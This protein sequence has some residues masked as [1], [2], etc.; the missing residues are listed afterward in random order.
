MKRKI[1]T[2]I[3]TGMLAISSVA[4][5]A[6]ATQTTN[7]TTTTSNVS[8]TNSNSATTTNN[9]SATNQT[10]TTTSTTKIDALDSANLFS[11]RDKEIGYDETQSK[12]ITLNNQSVTISE[13]GTYILSGT[14]TNGQV[15]VD[16]PKEAKITIVL[17]GV[18]I[19]NNTSAAIYVKQADKV[20]IT[21]AQGSTN[22]LSN[23][24]EFVAI[25]ENNIDGV[26]YSKEDLTINGQGKL[27]VNANYGNAIVSKDDLTITSGT[28]ELTAANHGLD[29]KDNVK[30]S[31]GTITINAGKDAI[32][33]ENTDDTSLGYIYIGGGKLNLTAASDA[34]DASSTIQIDAGQ[35]DIKAEDDG[36]HGEKRVIINAGTININQSAEGIEGEKIDI[37]GGDINVV[38]QDDGLNATS[39]STTTTTTQNQQ[40]ANSIEQVPAMPTDGQRPVPPEF[41][42]GQA[43]TIPADGQRPTPPEFSNGQMMKGGMGG[44]T[45]ANQVDAYISISGGNLIIKAEGDG[46]DSNG[47]LIVTGGTTYVYGPTNSG[48]GSLDY[49]G[50]AKITGGV[51]VTAGSSGMAQNFGTDST[52]GT[53]LINLNS[54]QSANTQVTVKNS[55]GKTILTF[56]PEK[57]YSSLLISSPEIKQGET[58]EVTAGSQTQTVTMT[59]TVY[60]SGGGMGGMKGGGKKNMQAPTTTN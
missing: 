42:N 36:I 5:S 59:S 22:T 33:A 2:I 30:I 32:H 57:Q 56:T 38:S 49:N 39:G 31:D 55:S 25:D 14:I 60:G 50:S 26:L 20:F 11:N 24:S 29:G 15:V 41:S 3:I 21:L 28:Y 43:P 48:N 19:N 4:C 53:M 17:D 10:S 1:A 34:M 23:K 54:T 7:N 45:N 35:I 51:F 8:T 27:I 37:T 9:S 18:T 58:Y 52:Q 16:A 44:G 6:A 13:E 40:T 12:K 46:V 47:S